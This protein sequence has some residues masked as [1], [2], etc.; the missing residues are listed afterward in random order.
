MNGGLNLG[1]WQDEA[2]SME[3]AKKSRARSDG[4]KTRDAHDMGD[5][6]KIREHKS[7]SSN[8]NLAA[9]QASSMR[10]ARSWQEVDGNLN[11]RIY[12]G[13]HGRI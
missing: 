5:L 8:A 2:L 1:E 4:E 9:M 12:G 7:M 6:A 11:A 13:D 3:L 10:L